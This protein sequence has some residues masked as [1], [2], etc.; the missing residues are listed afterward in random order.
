MNNKDQQFRLT[1]I[2]EMINEFDDI[3]KTKCKTL[4]EVVFFDGILSIIESKYLPKEKK[5]IVDTWQNGFD[6]A[7]IGIKTTG[8]I[9]Y[10]G[11]DYFKEIFK[12]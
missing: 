12:H 5:Q 6:I 1:A 8:G 10:D 2:Q 4:Q 7:H 11:D 3:K 9:N